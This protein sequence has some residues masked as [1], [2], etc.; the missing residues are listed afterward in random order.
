MLWL[1][2]HNQQKIVADR[3]L[4]LKMQADGEWYGIQTGPQGSHQTALK[5]LASWNHPNTIF[6][7]FRHPQRIIYATIRRAGVGSVNFS[8]LLVGTIAHQM[9]INKH[10][11]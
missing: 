9:A 2:Y 5:V 4:T 6:L 8:H 10:N 11:E 7:K 1:I 3:Q